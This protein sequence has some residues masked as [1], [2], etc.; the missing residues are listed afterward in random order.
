[1]PLDQNCTKN[2]TLFSFKIEMESVDY[3][4]NSELEIEENKLS[5]AH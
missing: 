4:C 5:F 3:R 1:M 2:A